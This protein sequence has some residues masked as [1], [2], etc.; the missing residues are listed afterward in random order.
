MT[1]KDHIDSL[2]PQMMHVFV[3]FLQE[4]EL[5]GFQMIITQSYRSNTTQ[6]RLCLKNKSNAAPGLSAHQYGFA[7]DFN[8]IKD[9][10]HLKKDST[11]KEWIDSGIVDIIKKHGL[12]WGGDFS[13][14]YDPI[15]IDCVK[16]GDTVRWLNYLK[17]TYGNNY[18]NKEC[19]KINWKL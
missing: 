3:A 15:H 10:V 11:I 14:Y 9:R 18:I 4:C 8:A 5:N 19:N 17:T 1:N 7:L 12:R 6:H 13:N 2:N 16:A